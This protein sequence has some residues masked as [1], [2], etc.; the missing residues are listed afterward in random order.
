[1]TVAWCA[2]VLLAAPPA[3]RPSGA[4]PQSAPERELERKAWAEV[5]K[6]ELP[7]GGRALPPPFKWQLQN[8]LENIDMPGQQ[9]SGGVPVKL[10]AVRVK[11]N[12][13]GV[14]DQVVDSFLKQGLY[15]QPLNQQAQLTAETQVTALDTERFIS[16]SAI[17]RPEPGGVCTVVLGEANIG[18]AA[19]NRQLD[20]G[21]AELAPVPELA[22]HR[23]ASRAEGLESLTFLV[24]MPEAQLKAWYSTEM[25]KRGYEEQGSVFRKG[26]EHISLR[27]RANGADTAVLLIKREVSPGE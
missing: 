27:T 3:Q 11:N 25:H 14:L 9:E 24:A 21:R 18:L 20:Q 4:G 23:L 19:V 22:R 17:I 2:L 12:L 7:D 5:S 8:V 16:Y 1:M 26:R 13:R 15:M 6:G 10:H